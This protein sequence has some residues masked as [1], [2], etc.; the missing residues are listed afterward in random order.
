MKAKILYL[1]IATSIFVACN[2][3]SQ[4]TNNEQ[5]KNEITQNPNLK[6]QIYY[7][8]ATHRCPTCNSIEANIK[9][10]LESNFKNEIEQGIINFTVLNVEDAE[11]KNLAEK[12]Q[13][14]GAALH[15]VDIE[16]GTE[17]DND[18]TKY[19]FSYSRKQPDVFLKGMNDTINYF[20]K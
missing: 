10:V 14:T 8:H 13:A 1:F 6:L 15:L 18:L 17:K 9:Q 5:V 11:N 12:F 19:A 7:F 20:L 3:G 16:N 2:Q 4:K